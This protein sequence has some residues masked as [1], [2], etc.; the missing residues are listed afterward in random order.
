MRKTALT[1][2][3]RIAL[4]R[5]LGDQLRYDI[6]DIAKS[7]YGLEVLRDN[8]YA[9]ALLNAHNKVYGVDAVEVKVFIKSGVGCE[10]LPRNLKLSCE[11]FGNFG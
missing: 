6:G 8:L 9:C 7:A 4:L 2:G 10:L 11:N 5:L 1:R 3:R